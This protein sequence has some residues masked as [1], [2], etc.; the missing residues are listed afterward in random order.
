MRALARIAAYLIERIFGVGLR[1]SLTVVNI[2]IRAKNMEST[3]PEG[4]KINLSVAGRNSRQEVIPINGIPSWS[5]SDPSIVAITP[6]DDGLTATVAGIA[7]GS[8]TVT[9]TFAG[10]SDSDTVTVTQ[11]MTLAGITLAA[12][13]PA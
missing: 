12:T 8:A 7:R 2:T 10:F 13:N 11:D 5:S 3:I 4:Q 6:A 9:V 1:L